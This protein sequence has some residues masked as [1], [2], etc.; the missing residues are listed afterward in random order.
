MQSAFVPNAAISGMVLSVTI[1]WTASTPQAQ[2]ATL[3][4]AEAGEGT[5]TS[6]VSV[7]PGAYGFEGRG[8]DSGGPRT[9]ELGVGTQTSVLGSFNQANFAWGGLTPFE[10]SWV[11]GSLVSVK[12]GST[13][14][15]YASDWLVGNALRVIAKRDAF[16]TITEVDGQSL[17]GGVGSAGGSLTELLYITG[18]SLLDGW[19]LKGQIQIAGGGNSLNEVLITSGNFTPAEPVPEPY[20]AVALLLAAGSAFGLTRRPAKP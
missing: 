6:L 4:F 5:F 12:V 19:T 7:N 2:A 10:M 1:G 20:S 3:R 14:L 11:P 17:V 16:L 8:G 15:F 18:D 9:W 13:S